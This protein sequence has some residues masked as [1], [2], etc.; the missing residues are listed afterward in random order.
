MPIAPGIFVGK[1]TKDALIGRL[2]APIFEGVK[3]AREGKDPMS[4]V[5]GELLP[6]NVLELSMEAIPG[7]GLIPGSVGPK[8][9]RAWKSL[10]E[11]KL[12]DSMRK[13]AQVIDDI[14][15]MN[16]SKVDHADILESITKSNIDSGLQID[17]DFIMIEAEEIA[18]SR[19]GKSGVTLEQ[20]LG[21]GTKTAGARGLD[22]PPE[23]I[24]V[25]KATKEAIAPSK[26]SIVEDLGPT[27]KPSIVGSTSLQK[28]ALKDFAEELKSNKNF[29]QDLSTK[30]LENILQNPD[31]PDASKG[32]IREVLDRRKKGTAGG[33]PKKSDLM[34]KME[35]LSKSMDEVKKLGL[36]K[37]LEGMIDVPKGGIDFAGMHVDELRKL[38]DDPGIGK[39]VKDEIRKHVKSV[40]KDVVQLKLDKLKDKAHFAKEGKPTVKGKSIKPPI[41]MQEAEKL[42]EEANNLNKKIF[43]GTI[44]SAEERRLVEIRKEMSKIIDARQKDIL[45]KEI[46]KPLTGPVKSDK[47]GPVKNI[48][49]EEIVDL[50]KGRGPKKIED[51]SAKELDKLLDQLD[52]KIG[53]SQSGNAPAEELMDKAGDLWASKT[54]KALDSDFLKK[55]EEGNKKIDD[56]LKKQNALTKGMKDIEKGK[57]PTVKGKALEDV[58]DLVDQGLINENTAKSLKIK[59][60]QTTATR[61]EAEFIIKK[62][63]WKPTDPTA[64]EQTGEGV[65]GTDFL[66]ELGDKQSYDLKTLMEWLGY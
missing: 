28:K 21:K 18:K 38:L 51:M 23:S 45:K 5:A 22:I 58:E 26:F 61:K 56:F 20:K 34:N 65:K 40:D 25:S 8:V 57:N 42:A 36:H 15:G 27:K 24:Q 16:L 39:N 46:K 66:S 19:G 52:Q 35:G 10:S 54:G 13:M 11:V 7:L 47:L 32:I 37:K 3:K 49:T 43:N 64:F 53:S 63:G 59:P 14:V 1:A 17:L 4:K 30:Q 44:S 31:L 62:H 48:R 55:V 9:A 50:L 12:G 33:R 60:G 2:A 41:M 29:P 6:A